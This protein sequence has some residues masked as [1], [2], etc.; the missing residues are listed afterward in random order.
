M[1]GSQISFPFCQHGQKQ[2]ACLT[3]TAFQLEV[4]AQ[5]G[6]KIPAAQAAVLI[7]DANRIKSILGGTK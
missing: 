5:S 4:R 2:A 3:L 6:K 1:P 7:A